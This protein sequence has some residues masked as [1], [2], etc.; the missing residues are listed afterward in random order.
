[1]SPQPTVVLV[2]EDEGEVR[3]FLRAILGGHGYRV[4]EA[5]SGEECLRE[6][7][8]QRTDLILLDLGL[9]DTDGI[10]VVGRLREWTAVP[11]LVVTARGREQDKVAALDAGADDYLTKPFGTDELL[12][13]IR[14]SLRHATAAAAGS[15]ADGASLAVGRLR[16]DFARREVKVDDRPVHLTPIEF[17]LVGL[18]ARHG[19]KVLTHKQMLRE[20][21]GPNATEQTHYLRVHMANL[22][23]KIESDPARPELLLTELGVGYRLHAP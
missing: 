7:A 9:P 23:R 8:Q 12:A 22:R 1:V 5:A 2:V 10:E 3:R 17:R 11:I 18:L 21:W 19:G 14:V 20:V 13:R 16:I 4:V 15:S 6:A